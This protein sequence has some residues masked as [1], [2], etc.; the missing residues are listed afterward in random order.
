MY[1]MTQDSNKERS[2]E[3]EVNNGLSAP[4]DTNL[5]VITKFKIADKKYAL[6]L[7]NKLS[8]K[9]RFMMIR[10]LL[11]FKGVNVFTFSGHCQLGVEKDPSE[12]EEA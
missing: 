11:N 6:A 3:E 1:E 5:V 8:L 4:S 2:S 10:S 12:V 9:E 7:Y